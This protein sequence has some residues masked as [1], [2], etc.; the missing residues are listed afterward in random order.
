MLILRPQFALAAGVP[1]PAAVDAA[2][3]GHLC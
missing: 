1:L 2:G 3:A